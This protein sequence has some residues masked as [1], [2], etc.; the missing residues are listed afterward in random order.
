MPAAQQRLPIA[1]QG[2]QIATENARLLN[3]WIGIAATETLGTRFCV[4]CEYLPTCQKMYLLFA[5]SRRLH[6][7]H[8]A[9]KVL[10]MFGI[11]SEYV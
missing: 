2:E 10:A 6:P 3:C 5:G 1:L 9:R 8:L 11:E 4:G 7:A